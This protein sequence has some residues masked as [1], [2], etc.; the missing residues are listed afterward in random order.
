MA[1]FTNEIKELDQTDPNNTMI[2]IDQY[3]IDEVNR[4]LLVRTCQR[5]SGM[6]FL[7]NAISNCKVRIE[8]GNVSE[9]VV[10]TQDPGEDT[11]WNVGDYFVY[12]LPIDVN[13]GDFVQL[14]F[15]TWETGT[16]ENPVGLR[17][18]VQYAVTVAGLRY[19]LAGNAHL[20]AYGIEN[21][22][23]KVVLYPK[24]GHTINWAD[25]HITSDSIQYNV[26]MDSVLGV[27]I[28]HQ[29]QGTL[30]HLGLKFTTE[31]G[32]A[33]L[34]TNGESDIPVRNIHTYYVGFY[35]VDAA[36]D[37]ADFSIQFSQQLNS[38]P[39]KRVIAHYRADKEGAVLIG[40]QNVSMT[41]IRDTDW[42]CHV[43]LLPVRTVVQL[44]FTY[45]YDETDN[46]TG[47]TTERAVDTTWSSTTV[48][49][50]HRS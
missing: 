49:I 14:K 30:P 17:E 29:I 20:D 19:P 2:G 28:P 18:S 6:M 12:T 47:Q 26:R 33:A 3:A 16:V 35:Q 31:E 40:P 23:R 48:Y 42:T 46:K 22:D 37:A 5:R 38:V 15:F 34:D 39:I 45:F 43:G 36:A 9:Y 8:Y 13:N 32:T 7:N 25:V 24:S 10:L 1:M 44:A 4:K 41:K 21:Q 27:V 50:L 11:Y